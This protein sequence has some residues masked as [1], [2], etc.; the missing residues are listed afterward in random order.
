MLKTFSRVIYGLLSWKVLAYVSIRAPQSLSECGRS[1]ATQQI[2]SAEEK[3]SWT[4]FVYQHVRKKIVAPHVRAWGSSLWSL[5]S[6]GGPWVSRG[7]AAAVDNHPA[8]GGQWQASDWA[9]IFNLRNSGMTKRC[10]LCW[11]MPSLAVAKVFLVGWSYRSTMTGCEPAQKFLFLPWN[12]MSPPLHQGFKRK[13]RKT[14]ML[15]ALPCDSDMSSFIYRRKI[16]G[17]M[18]SKMMCVTKLFWISP[19]HSGARGLHANHTEC[20]EKIILIWNKPSVKIRISA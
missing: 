10:C 17:V 1:I 4:V 3:V 15:S 14:H 2:P 13:W 20:Y 8:L 9:V 5:W 11:L 18:V 19:L 7:T 16:E 6:A 12:F